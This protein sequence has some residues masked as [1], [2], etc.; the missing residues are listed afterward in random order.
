[1]LSAFSSSSLLSFQNIMCCHVKRKILN[2][3]L[4]KYNLYLQARIQGR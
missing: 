1:M 4:S 3:W 2:I